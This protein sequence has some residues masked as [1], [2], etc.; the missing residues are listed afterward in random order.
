MGQDFLGVQVRG[1]DHRPAR[2]Q[3]IRQSAAGN[4]VLARIGRNVHVAGLQVPQ[5]V[6]KAE[7]LVDETHIRP[8][9][10]I[11]GHLDQALAVNLA[12]LTLDLRVGGAHDQVDDLGKGGDDAGHGLNH[13][14]QPLAST[15]EPEG[16]DDLPSRESQPSLVRAVAPI[17]DL[18]HS[19]RN[20]PHLRP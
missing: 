3:G 7:V 20:H 1:A 12:F 9:T 19:M 4:L 17:R 16:A 6:A 8:D 11:L 2:R 13:V 15:D 5:Q 10:Q 18:R 14:F